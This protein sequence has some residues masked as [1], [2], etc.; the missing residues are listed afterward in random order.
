MQTM[1]VRGGARMLVGIALAT[2]DGHGGGA[3][4]ALAPR[5][6]PLVG[7]AVHSV[8]SNSSECIALTLVSTLAPVYDVR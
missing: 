3:R 5:P 1:S 7:C 6:S 8:R 4:G 2:A